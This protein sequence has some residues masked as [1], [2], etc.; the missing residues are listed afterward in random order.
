M[1]EL[2]PSRKS[3]AHRALMEMYWRWQVNPVV[4]WTGSMVPAVP[5]L[6]VLTVPSMFMLTPALIASLYAFSLALF[7]KSARSFSR[8]RMSTPSWRRLEGVPLSDGAKK[9]AALP[10]GKVRSTSRFH[11][12]MSQLANSV[13]L[14]LVQLLLLF[15]L[16][17]RL[18][19]GVG[20]MELQSITQV[21]TLFKALG[22]TFIRSLRSSIKRMAWVRLMLV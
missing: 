18:A 14:Q 21:S 5:L 13:W 7:S 1:G 2:F 11:S 17:K 8:Q 4:H 3:G 12:R 19:C 16:H 9:V 15:M 10:W 20:V 22:L 6:L